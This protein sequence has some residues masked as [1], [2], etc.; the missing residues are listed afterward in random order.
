MIQCNLYDIINI[1]LENTLYIIAI[2]EMKIIDSKYTNVITRTVI[3][4]IS[5]FITA[6]ILL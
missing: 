2:L 4:S 3:V 6:A 1:T 5:T